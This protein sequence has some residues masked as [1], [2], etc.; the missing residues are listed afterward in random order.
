MR[1][2]YIAT[3]IQIMQVGLKE[4]DK[5]FSAREFLLEALN[6]PN[7]DRFV[8]YYEGLSDKKVSKL[9]SRQSPV[10]DGI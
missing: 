9:V 1:E 4:H 10:P 5:Q 6:R 3:F 8:G 2:L 7:D